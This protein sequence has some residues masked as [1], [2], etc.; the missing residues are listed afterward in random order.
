MD[1]QPHKTSNAEDS[2]VAQWRRVTDRTSLTTQL[3]GV[4]TINYFICTVLTYFSLHLSYNHHLHCILADVSYGMLVIRVASDAKQPGLPL[5][6][7]FGRG[8]EDFTLQ[9]RLKL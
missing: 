4:L 1:F 3:S 9:V 6:E 7:G 5:V 8:L 2:Q